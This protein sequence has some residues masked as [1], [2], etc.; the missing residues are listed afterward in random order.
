MRRRP[1]PVAAL[2]LADPWP[3][4]PGLIAPNRWVVQPMEGWDALA[5]GSPSDLTLRRWRNFGRSGAGLVWGGEAAA[6]TPD[7]RGNP[8]QLVVSDGTAAGLGALRRALL[9]VAAEAGNPTP[10][11]GL[12]LT[13][14]GRWACPTSAGPRP[15]IAYSHPLLDARSGAT[16]DDVVTDA[17]VDALVA[18][19]ARSAA[20]AQSEGFDFVDLKHCHGYLLHEFLAARR[21]PGAWGGPTLDD[22]T[23]LIRRVSEAVRES[24]PAS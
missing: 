2:P 6:V 20:L 4:A 8:H 22:R 16:A 1:A 3:L 17:D 14:S 9:D 21:R 13:H 7:G 15:R 24:A 10:I 18:A 19:F 5:D 12:Q 11:V 23:R